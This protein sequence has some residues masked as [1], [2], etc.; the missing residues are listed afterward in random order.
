MSDASGHALI[1][2]DVQKDFCEGGSLAVGGGGECAGR[3]SDLLAEHRGRYD[4][5]VA[6]KDWHID[7]GHH[8]ADEPDFVDTWPAHC[9]AETDGAEFHPDIHRRGDVAPLLD[10]TFLKGQYAPSYSGFEG[11]TTSGVPLAAWLRDNAIASVDVI[12]I[13]TRGCV[14]A[15][16][17]DAVKEGFDTTVLLDLCAD[18]AEPAGATEEALGEMRAAG[19]TIGESALVG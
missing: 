3:I 11:A 5:V 6:T 2:V 12:G 4:K 19:I 18:P 17:L 8:F 10:E 16:A 9:R 15:T 14:K 13:A 7:P 1:V